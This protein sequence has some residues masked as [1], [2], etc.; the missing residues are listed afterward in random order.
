MIIDRRSRLERFYQEH[1]LDAI[2]FTNILNV[3]Y[4]S[5][6]SGSEAM[7]VTAADSACWLLCDS[8]YT[9]QAEAETTHVEVI[10]FVERNSAL[11]MLFA[12]RGLRRI[13]V[14]SNHMTVAAFNAVASALQGCE[15]VP[16]GDE[17][18]Q[19]RAVKDQTEIGMLEL[20]ARLASDALLSALSQF[21][22]GVTEARLA[23]ELEIE[24]LRRGAQGKA[25]DFI[26]ASGERG[27]MPHGR[28]SDKRIMSGE[29]LTI[30]FGAVL[31]GYHSDETVTFSIGA[32]DNRCR[33]I[34]AVVKE[35]HDLAVA[36]ARPGMTCRQ[37][38][39]VAR[40][41][42]RNSGYGEFFGHGLGHGVGLEIHEKPTVSPRS[43]I[44]L[45]EG[46]VFTIEPGIYIPGVGGV[47]IEDTV[48]LTSNGCR[49]LTSVPKEL[50]V[51]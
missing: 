51:L 9:I 45:Q 14:E 30:D 44:V 17:L 47:R 6:F 27:A 28:A 12:E 35:A 13:G 1:N 18:D 50:T 37:L 5:G 43:D 21:K 36:A 24:M 15:L 10:Q 40:D 26:V 34:H 7:L 48:C 46:M 11:A 22:V 19:I 49:L 29:L 42:I 4:L 39:A 8:R 3:R 32:P 2:L 41:Y 23:M 16:V 31:D 20:V 38:D 33:E 25:F